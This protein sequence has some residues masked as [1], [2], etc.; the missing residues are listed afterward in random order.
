MSRDGRYSG[1]PG[2][3]APLAAAIALALAG[4]PLPTVHAA[5]GDAV[6]DPITVVTQSSIYQADVA[7]GA[8]GNFTVV[9]YDNS[10]SVYAACFDANGN[11]IGN[12]QTLSS[13]GYMVRVAADADGNSVAVWDITDGTL[14]LGAQR[15]D[16]SCTPQGDPITITTKISL[17]A[18][19]GVAMGP[20]GDFVIFWDDYSVNELR[21]QRYDAAG[22]PQGGVVT[23]ASSTIGTGQTFAAARADG[24][25][26]V[27]WIDW[28]KGKLRYYAADGS[29]L[30]DVIT[31]N[32]LNT[33]LAQYQNVAMDGD[34]DVVLPW[35]D[36]D[37][38]DYGIYAQRYDEVGNADGSRLLASV[39]NGPVGDYD[40]GAAVDDDGDFMVVW[41]STSSGIYTRRYDTADTAGDEITVS[42][43]GGSPDVAMDADGDAVVVWYGGGAIKA[44]RYQGKGQT[45]D[46]GVVAG[47]DAGGLI[48]GGEAITYTYT[49]TNNGSGSA[50]DITLE[51]VSPDEL[52]Y[53]SLSADTDWDCA[54]SA[55]TVTCTLPRMVSGGSA[56]LTVSY[57]NA[58][59][60]D[61]NLVNTVSVS[62]PMSD[63]DSS[64]DSATVTLP[65]TL[66]AAPGFDSTPAISGTAAVG[67]TVSVDTP[68]TEPDGDDY[69]VTYQWYADGAAITGA[70]SDSYSVTTDEAH[71]TLT[72]TLTATDSNGYSATA[73]ASG[74][75]VANA[76]PSF[77]A[78]PSIDGTGLVGNTLTAVDTAT[79]DT[80]ADSVTLSYQWQADGVDISGAT[81]ESYTLTSAEAHSA[82][83]AV[84]T[85]A[86]GYDT[87]VI[88]TAPTAMDNSAPE[89]SGVDISGSTS[90][91]ET[92]IV[93]V[94]GVDRDGDPLTYSYE[95][96]VDGALSGTAASY[97]VADGDEGKTLFA[98]VT[99]SDGNGGSDRAASTARVIGN[100][101][102]VFLGTPSI[103]G[104]AAVGNT[105]GL[106]G[107]AVSDAEGDAVTIGYQWLLDDAPIDGATADSYTI[108]SS[109]AGHAIACTVTIADGKG[110]STSVTT[111]AKTVDADSGA[112]GTGASG[113]GGGAIGGLVAFIRRR[114]G[115][116]AD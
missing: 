51:S 36:Y 37:G 88:T 86:D 108:Q 94:S 114:R 28:G 12:Q 73:T 87:T 75:A 70:T 16:S 109:D 26:V 19:P 58:T 55:G 99:V 91:G 34:G 97:T 38:S 5:V 78:T 57:T 32:S 60:S 23:V 103:S 18:Y 81:A 22:T 89:I 35:Y 110:G 90:P 7:M 27:G 9:W 77:D 64:N 106:S 25:F 29:P 50:L 85:A 62:T 52:T 46:L 68:V 116:R 44:Q 47:S 56:S 72:V 21:F 33:T 49:V 92:V 100:E 17:T 59:V 20:Q 4:V 115:T 11:P 105:L 102:P 30:T 45:V 6:G 82:I 93:V 107:T 39:A 69:T 76:A 65:T 31:N 53:A 84:V 14:D 15:L 112:A 63:T 43:G 101:G 54:E 42:S 111:A 40:H 66:N 80:D 61:G 71:T 113:G 67:N 24:G 96:Y 10:S 79:S 83:T 13:D 74:V 104:T 48:G 8:E 41:T 3:R 95:W 98:I 1:A 2:R